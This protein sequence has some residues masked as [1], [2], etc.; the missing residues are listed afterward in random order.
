[1]HNFLSAWR[2]RMRLA[3]ARTSAGGGGIAGA[4]EGDREECAC[5]YAECVAA[6]LK[7]T[8]WAKP[9]T[10]HAYVPCLK[11]KNKRHTSLSESL[12]RLSLAP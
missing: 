8:G 9:I 5:V 4:R 7:K 2:R 1:M 10:I 12:S 11:K 6:W 3:L